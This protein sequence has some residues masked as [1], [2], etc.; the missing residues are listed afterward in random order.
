[1]FCILSEDT[2]KKIL[3][4]IFVT[5]IVS[6]SPVTRQKA[7]TLRI[8]GSDTMLPLAQ[9]WAQVYMIENP[10]VSVYVEGGGTA[11]G[12]SALAQGATDICMASRPITPGEAQLLVHHFGAVGVSVLVA[13]DAL[14]LYV[15]PD[16]PVKN[17]T[18]QQVK[19]IFSGAIDN[20]KDLGGDNAPIQLLNR[21]PTS[22]TYA[23]FQ[24]HVLGGA[25]YDPSAKALPTTKAIVD[26]VSQHK[27]AIGY[28]GVAYEADIYH[29]DINGIAP[30]HENVIN[31]TYP[32]TR[33]LYLYTVDK[34]HGKIKDFINWTVNEHGQDI[35]SWV[36]YFPIW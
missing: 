28:G 26:F 27:N 20:W 24:E 16:N 9:F 30:S 19:N 4:F 18:M 33:Y 25:S 7:V 13:K 36:G 34:P 22:G 14:S 3:I 23:Y 11:I 5:L 17:L 35:V 2:L 1:M 31:D 29:C 8:K 32:L 21:L 12:M 10:S 15:H 6:C